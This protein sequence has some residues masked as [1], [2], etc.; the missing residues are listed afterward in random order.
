MPD[1]QVGESF[2]RR[3]DVKRDECADRKRRGEAAR[4]LVESG[5]RGAS[6]ECV[7]ARGENGEPRLPPPRKCQFA[8]KRRVHFVVPHQP[9][10]LNGPN[11]PFNFDHFSLME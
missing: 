8:H 1:S 4:R 2:A 9:W 7:T 3:V 11:W 6:W 10:R 5:R